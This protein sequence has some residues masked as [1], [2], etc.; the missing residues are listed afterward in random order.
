MVLGR[1]AQ[2]G[3]RSR[4]RFLTLH[5]S[6]HRDHRVLKRFEDTALRVVSDCPRVIRN[7]IHLRARLQCRADLDQGPA[8]REAFGRVED[9]EVGTRNF[10]QAFGSSARPKRTAILRGRSC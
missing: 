4:A 3:N 6:L 8:L 5:A 10:A 7:D 1:M 2:I 9:N